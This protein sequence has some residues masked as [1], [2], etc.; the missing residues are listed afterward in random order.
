MYILWN[1]YILLIIDRRPIARVIFFTLY[2]SL[3]NLTNILQFF[4]YKYMV[5]IT[6]MLIINIGLLSYYYYIYTK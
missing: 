3:I 5:L 6:N 1:T 4:N 2:I